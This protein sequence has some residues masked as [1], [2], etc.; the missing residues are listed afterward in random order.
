NPQALNDAASGE[1]TGDGRADLVA[2]DYNDVI[3]FPGLGDGTFGAAQFVSSPG[4]VGA[5]TAADFTGDA[6]D[7][8]AVTQSCCGG[9]TILVLPGNGDGTYQSPIETLVGL[10]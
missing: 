1:F 10:D 4:N 7:D 5:I 9:Q 2:T 3:L 6:R 8:V